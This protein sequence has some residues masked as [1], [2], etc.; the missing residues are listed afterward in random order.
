M[1]QRGIREF[2]AKSLLKKHWKQYFKDQFDYQTTS[3]LVRSSE[4]LSAAAK[5]T[6]WLNKK[7]LVVKPDMLFGG[8]GKNNLVLFKKTTAGDI[9]LQDALN[10][11]DEKSNAPI[12]LN[13][14]TQ[15]QLN[16]FIIEPFMPHKEEQEYYLSIRTEGLDDIVAMSACGGVDIM[17]NWD[18]VTEIKLPIGADDNE[19][20]SLIESHVPESI[21]D[22]DTFGKFAT[23]I[24][25]FFKDLH[26]SYF[27]MNPFILDENKIH[28]LDMVAKLDDT[29]GYLMTEEWGETPFPTGFGQAELSKE[30]ALI[31]DIDEKS[32]A[33]LKLTLLNPKGRVW[34]LVAGGGASVV[35]ADT[36]AEKWGAEQ[37]ATYGEYSGNPS[38]QETYTYAKTVID[39]MT[40]EQDPNGNAKILLIGGAIANFTDVA[41]TFDGII[42]AFQDYS[43]QMKAANVRIYVRRGGPNYEIGLKNIRTA[44]KKLELPIEVYGPETHMT[45]IIQIALEDAA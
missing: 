41:K 19:A 36:I 32:G 9:Q 45:D 31:R 42:K 11:I 33:S 44:A 35:F 21:K 24:Y 27:E 37:M 5:K 7:A 4:E 26:F 28:A 23:G 14:G 30:E 22:K 34:T 25:K 40:R 8:R 39:L 12:T 20:A 13:D 15:G 17:E 38:T 2:H 43:E 6:D 16:Q 10:W 1:A 29:A 3:V 18:K